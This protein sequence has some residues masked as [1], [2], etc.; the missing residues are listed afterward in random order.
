M[1]N[2]PVSVPYF[3]NS[4]VICSDCKWFPHHIDCMQNIHS[5]T[6]SLSVTCHKKKMD[7]TE[8]L[9]DIA[10]P[11]SN[12]SNLSVTNSQHTLLYS[13]D[14]NRR[15]NITQI[16]NKPINSSRQCFLKSSIKWVEGWFPADLYTT[17]PL[18]NQRHCPLLAIRKIHPLELHFSDPEALSI[19]CI[20]S[21]VYQHHHY[22]LVICNA[23]IN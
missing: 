11:Y 5:V 7:L 18:G 1:A 20:V 12:V 8:K 10:Q 19:L 21:G 6:T 2:V 14:M 16:A 3:L 13:P 17:E 22:L 15:T 9:K 23:I 4:S